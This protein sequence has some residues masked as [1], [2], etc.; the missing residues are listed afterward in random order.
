MGFGRGS[1]VV[2]MAAGDTPEQQRAAWRA[3]TRRRRDRKKQSL[4]RVAL[5]NVPHDSFIGVDAGTRRLVRPS[6]R[7]P[8]F[9]AALRAFE[10]RVRTA[11][12]YV[13]RVTLRSLQRSPSDEIVGANREAANNE[14]AEQ[15]D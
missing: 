15:E 4:E 1:V 9:K 11:A 6:G 13:S 10:E 14:Y 3:R 8:S 5:D 7:A 12:P 2:M